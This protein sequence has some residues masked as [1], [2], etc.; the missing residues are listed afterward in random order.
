M[1]AEAWVREHVGI[2][3]APEIP[4]TGSGRVGQSGAA[5]MQ[6]RRGAHNRRPVPGV[7][8][9]LRELAF[10][11][12]VHPTVAGGHC[13]C[14]LPSLVWVPSHWRRLLATAHPYNYIHSC[15]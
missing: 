2:S 7:S 6:R 1:L 12:Y 3:A 14:P 5:V 9:L 10:F 11:N 15:L 4:Q 13:R 8:L